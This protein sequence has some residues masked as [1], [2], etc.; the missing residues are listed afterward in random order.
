M[1][2]NEFENQE[3][4]A[5]LLGIASE[6]KAE[7]MDELSV[8]DTDFAD[9]LGVAEKDLIDAYVQGELAGPDL[10]RFEEHFLLS[11]HRREKVSFARAF[12]D[13][14][15]R[16]L[17][18]NRE[19]TVSDNGSKSWLAAFLA[20]FGIVGGGQPAFRLAMAAVALLVVALGGWVIVR[21]M[22]G[23]RSATEVASNININAVAPVVQQSSVPTVVETPDVE[24]PEQVSK[25]NPSPSPKPP[26]VQQTRPLIASFV[27]GPPLRGTNVPSLSIPAATDQA[28]IRL[29][30]ES[31]EFKSY[32]I[33]LKDGTNGRVIWMDSRV[34]ASGPAGRRSA[35]VRIPAKLFNRAI[36]ALVVSG[37]AEGGDPEIIGDYPFRVVR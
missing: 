14:S 8:A 10:K 21:N 27:L 16:N 19:A 15:G 22:I 34:S 2:T 13:Y 30:L 5:Y 6:E 26:V 11:P 18:A 23:D 4:R 12:Q 31:D 7:A 3:L 33:E 9:A 28:A 24:V 37:I 1:K 20:S 35:N 32:K 29:E 36:Y 25:P 17:L